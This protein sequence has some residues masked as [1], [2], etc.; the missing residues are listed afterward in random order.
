MPAD[1]LSCTVH[2]GADL[3]HL[4]VEELDEGREDAVPVQQGHVLS[5]HVEAFGVRLAL[6]PAAYKKCKSSCHVNKSGHMKKIQIV[7]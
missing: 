7:D 5:A 4:K 2:S 3:L 6:E 1:E